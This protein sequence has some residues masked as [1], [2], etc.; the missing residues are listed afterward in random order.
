LSSS[1]L[2]TH[3]DLGG[4]TPALEH[5]AEDSAAEEGSAAVAIRAA[6]ISASATN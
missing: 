3:K 4:T 2:S 5:V 1:N 6:I